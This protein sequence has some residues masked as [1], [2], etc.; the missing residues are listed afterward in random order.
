M[1]DIERELDQIWRLIWSFLESSDYVRSGSLPAHAG[2]Q[3]MGLSPRNQSSPQPPWG[4][5]ASDSSDAA[6]GPQR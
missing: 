4:Q 3:D 5:L 2:S 6:Q 1:E